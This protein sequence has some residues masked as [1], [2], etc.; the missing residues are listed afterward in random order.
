LVA[1]GGALSGMDRDMK[2]QEAGQLAYDDVAYGLIAHMDLAYLVSEDLE[3]T[4][5]LD[6]RLQAKEMAPK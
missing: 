1:E 2:L 5:K 4:A 3:W 6:H